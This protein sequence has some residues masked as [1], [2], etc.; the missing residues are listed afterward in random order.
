MSCN[1]GAGGS[2]GSDSTVNSITPPPTKDTSGAVA[3]MMGD[4]SKTEVDSLK[5]AS[6]QK[7]MVRLAKLE[8]DPAQLDSYK[9]FLKEEVET[10]V[11][12]E[13]GVLTLF[14]VFEKNHP[15]SLTI[16]EIYR[17][18]A[19]YQSHIQTPHFL[20]YKNGTAKMVKSLELVEAIPLIPD[21]KIK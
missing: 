11:N 14:P 2:S 19:A 17:D 13:P 21:M 10:S 15:A 9:S 16:L 7:N 4:T 18:S 3:P 5:K 12:A 8:I 1:N 6:V 20:K